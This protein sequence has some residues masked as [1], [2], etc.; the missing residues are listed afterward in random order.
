MPDTIAELAAGLEFDAERI[1]RFVSDEI[2]YEPYSGILRGARGTLASRAGN[3]ADQALLL[4]ALLEASLLPVRFAIGELNG[5]AAEALL[6]GAETDADS[7]R[8]QWLD[9]LAGAVPGSE[10]LPAQLTPEQAEQ[11]ER[12]MADG[13]SVVAWA[14]DQLQRT[15]SMITSELKEAGVEFGDGMTPMPDSERA[16]HIWVQLAATAD[17]VDLDPTMPGAS[18]G[19]ALTTVDVTLAELPEDMAHQVELAVIGETLVGDTLTERRLV[20]YSER[21]DVLAGLPIAITN[22]DPEALTALGVSVAGALSG[23]ASYVPVII[24]GEDAVVGANPIYLTTQADSGAIEPA[25]PEFFD[26]GP[27]AGQTTAEWVELTIRSPEAE[28]V[29]VR[30]ELFDLIG[31]SRRSMGG[32]SVADLAP[33]HRIDIPD[34]PQAQALPAL[35]THWI[36]VSTGSPSRHDAI[37]SIDPVEDPRAGALM[38]Q[39]HHLMTMAMGSEIAAP[40]GLRPFIDA[41]NVVAYSLIMLP[42]GDDDR[43]AESGLDIWHRSHGVGAVKGVTSSLSSAVAAG[44]LAHVAERAIGGDA[45][46]D[47]DAS[48]MPAFASVGAIFDIA[49]ARGIPWRVLHGVGATSGLP[50]SDDAKI[51]LERSL[52]AGW[53][54]VAPERPVSIGTR[55]RVGWWLVDPKT[56][57]TMDELDD[58]RGANLTEYIAKVRIWYE[59]LPAW[60]RIGVCISILARGMLAVLNLAMTVAEDRSL[61]SGGSLVS[62]AAAATGPWAYRTAGC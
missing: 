49:K 34:G 46:H 23:G 10:S 36:T 20:G 47:Q 16:R 22:T 15:V 40:A 52:A 31:P 17:W 58:G 5:D 45:K 12:A 19:V 6:T 54:A 51:R 18:P 1:Y 8:E 13:D 53:F 35:A 56:G 60:I 29:V 37:M 33:V 27:L 38:S 32:I 14:Q 21:A 44:V 55:D 7:T 9:A 2:R 28:P 62:V 4:A 25:G 11:L 30:R 26:A 50:W 48:A 43:F 41:P 24:V 59:S 39:A 57:R 42:P 3:S 61:T